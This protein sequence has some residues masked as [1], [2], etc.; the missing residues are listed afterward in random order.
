MRPSPAPFRFDGH[1]INDADGKRICK[2]ISC[3]PYLE[4][5]KRN[6]EFDRLS[7]LF[8]SAPA[9][10]QGYEV[11]LDRLSFELM[12]NDELARYCR[13]MIDKASA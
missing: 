6:P 4:G 9:L 7:Y 2:V 8:A 11:I 12:T 10:V 1:G 13:W 3:E 5:S